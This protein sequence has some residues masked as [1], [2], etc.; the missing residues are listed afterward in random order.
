MTKIH[1]ISLPITN[2]TV[3]Y[4]NNPEIK[5][6]NFASLPNDS[7]GLTKISFGSHTGTHIDAPQHTIKK[8]NSIDEFSLDKFMGN[9][10]VYD[11]SHIERGQGVSVSDFSK[12]EPQKDEIVI[13]KT[14]NSNRDYK[15]FYN[16][17]VYLEPD[18]ATYL[19]ERKIK[20]F[21]ID[22]LSVKQK[23][24]TD[25]RSHNEFLENDI[26]IVEG[27]F[28]K[29]IQEGVY[30]FIAF[31]LKFIGIDG[32]PTRAVLIDKN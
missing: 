26:P 21:G 20:L 5:I 4:P 7:S 12:R 11:F 15:E 17:F 6:E 16:D 23:G 1:D 8:G 18:A 22:Y 13:I 29:D 2:E 10:F 3:V 9:C 27:L 28:L 14:S 25:N 31:P 24:S 32:S 30:E 19:K